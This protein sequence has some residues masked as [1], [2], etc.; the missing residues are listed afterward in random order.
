M[1]SQ[2]FY[3][4]FL[5]KLSS[6]GLFI[7]AKSFP[8]SGYNTTLGL[9]VDKNSNIAL[10][11]FY[12]GKMD[13]NP[14]N[15][16]L[17][18]SAKNGSDCFIIKINSIGNFLW[19]KS[20]GD[21]LED[22]GTSI[23]FDQSGNIVVCGAFRGSVDFDPDSNNSLVL[24]SA[25]KRDVF[26][27]KLDSTGALV[28]TARYG[29]LEEEYG[30]L[31]ID[32]SGDFICYGSFS[33]VSDFDPSLSITNLTSQG[34]IDVYYLKLKNPST[35]LLPRHTNNIKIYPNPCKDILV[36]DIDNPI[37]EY[38]LF[39][40]RGLRINVTKD[41]QNQFNLGEASPGLYLLEVKTEKGIHVQKVIKE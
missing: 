33:G 28:W 34:P 38:N 36:L 20:L 41:K 27:S 18:V 13:L 21:T 37:I 6:D 24:T 12:T 19:G 29:G 35:G 40:S 30:Q 8:S 17:I 22:F 2:G 5:L 7:W 31:L 16:S 15:D 39:D 26:I 25:G 9:D 32:Y 1:I 4:S 23:A 10:T 14:D 3:D 11:G